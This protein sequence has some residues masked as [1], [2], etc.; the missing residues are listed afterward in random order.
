MKHIK[1][2]IYILLAT[3]L[4][5]CSGSTDDNSESLVVSEITTLTAQEAQYLQTA[6]EANVTGELTVSVG[7][8]LNLNAQQKSPLIKLVQKAVERKYE[9]NSTVAV[10]R[11]GD[12]YVFKNR[13]YKEV[14]TRRTFAGGV[15]TEYERD[16]F[17]KDSG[18]YEEFYL[19]IHNGPDSS[20]TINAGAIDSNIQGTNHGLYSTGS[21]HMGLYLDIIAT[22]F[23][24]EGSTDTVEAEA[25]LR[26]HF[27]VSFKNFRYTDRN[28]TNT[29][30]SGSFSIG[31]GVKLI[32]DITPYFSMYL[33]AEADASNMTGGSPNLDSLTLKIYRTSER[34]EEI[35]EVR[36]TEGSD[37][38]QVYVYNE[39]KELVLL[40]TY[41]DT[42]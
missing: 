30:N 9:T 8:D 23:L 26:G 42:I 2:F 6:Y 33:Y 27:Q 13:E 35:G 38:V 19:R 36:A 12:S 29:I 25:N 28:D 39:D 18:I 34:R 20:L 3:T 1:Y 10:A 7:S 32:D 24:E 40:E 31:M 37:E 21:M 41:I 16:V 11:R 5:G 15:V 17:H 22:Y 14:S 4:I